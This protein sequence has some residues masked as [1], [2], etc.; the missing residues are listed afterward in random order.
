MVKT[1]KYKPCLQ[2]H[3]VENYIM[4]HNTICTWWGGATKLIFYLHHC[5]LPQPYVTTYVSQYDYIL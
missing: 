3:F 4:L 1:A 5:T 2:D